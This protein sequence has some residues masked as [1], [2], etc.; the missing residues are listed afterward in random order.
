M[1][2]FFT[3]K[4]S[5]DF[6]HLKPANLGLFRGKQIYVRNAKRQRG[7]IKRKTAELTM[8][9]KYGLFDVPETKLST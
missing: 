3:P 4:S 9:S 8:Y 2:S 7:K 1:R 5:P 6:I